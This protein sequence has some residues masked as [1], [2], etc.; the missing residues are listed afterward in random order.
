[1]S[2]KNLRAIVTDLSKFDGDNFIVTEQSDVMQLSSLISDIKDTM[3]AYGNIP[4]LAA[5]QLGENVRLFC[6]RFY[7]NTIRTFV[8]PF[9]MKH[10]KEMVLSRETCASIP[11]KE[12]II[13]R[14]KKI[15]LQYQDEAGLVSNCILEDTSAAICQQMLDLVNGVTLEDYGLE[16]IDGYD[17]APEEERAE[18]IKYYLNWLQ[19][20]SV[21]LQKEVETNPKLYE[22]S[23]AI[24]FMTAQALGQVEV[25]QVEISKEEAEQLAKERENFYKEMEEKNKPV[26]KKKRGRPKKSTSGDK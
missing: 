15:Y 2:K 24:D 6:I 14:Y 9:L 16:V 12:F 18:V 7:D 20:M 10:E 21:D 23:K 25:E 22:M 5:P 13:P 26:E 1:M 17:D 11:G 3:K 8:N 19:Q 4:A